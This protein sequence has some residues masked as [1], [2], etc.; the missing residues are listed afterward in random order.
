MNEV[1]TVGRSALHLA[2]GHAQTAVVR[3]LLEYGAVA[4]VGDL[5][6]DTP[7]LSAIGRR[8]DGQ[9]TA[10]L[11]LRHLAPGGIRAVAARGS[12]GKSALHH[13]CLYGY[14]AAFDLI[15]QSLG[16]VTDQKEGV[17]PVSREL[18]TEVDKFLNACDIHGGTPLSLAVQGQ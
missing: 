15:I 17:V 12:L 18:A 16:G 1:N 3:L 4:D 10:L 7:L 9:R 8:I 13:A 14:S 6:G 5:R 2:A 11:L